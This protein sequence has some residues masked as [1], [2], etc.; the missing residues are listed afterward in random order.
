MRIW[1]IL[2]AA[3][4][5]RRM[6][7]GTPKQY[8]EVCG[9][10]ILLHSINRLLEVSEIEHLVVVLC[11][12]DRHWGMLGYTDKRVSTA[13]GG[14][15]RSVSVLNGLRA[16]SGRALKDD[17]VLVHDAVRPCISR[18][19]IEKLI[20]KLRQNEIG[21]LLATP[22]NN[23]IKRVDTKNLVMD[24]INRRDLWSALTPQMFRYGLLEN[25]LNNALEQ[26]LELTD[27]A[28]AI[29]ALGMQ[30]L[31]VPGQ[32]SNLKITHEADLKLAEII[33]ASGGLSY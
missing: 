14:D 12:E 30:P 25:A 28:G 24:T 5:G 8:L 4:I 26:D 6:G 1:A 3:G 11:Q 9:T 19:D 31:I 21:G 27:E 7:S 16:L 20:E 13:L 18:S 17:W 32:K 2:P 29:E 15:E 23:T 33:L 10:P 22:I